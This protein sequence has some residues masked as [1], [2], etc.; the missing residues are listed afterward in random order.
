[1]AA[2]NRIFKA[3]KPVLASALVLAGLATASTP[4]AAASTN[5]IGLCNKATYTSYLDFPAR[6][7][8]R[9]YMVAPGDCWSSAFTVGKREVVVVYAAFGLS[10]DTYIGYR[11]VSTDVKNVFRTYGTVD[12]PSFTLSR[13]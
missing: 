1:M 3:W 4:A 13:N 5:R 10:R 11:E 7:G 12:A 9:S 8:F 2:L 6:G